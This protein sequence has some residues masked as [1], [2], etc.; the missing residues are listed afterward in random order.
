MKST[1]NWNLDAPAKKIVREIKMKNFM[2]AVRLIDDIA[3]VAEEENHHPD[4]HLTGY[5]NL[6]VELS[7]HALNGLSENDF[8]LAAK[9]NG[10]PM[11]LRT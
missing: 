9:I 7:T 5:R 10:L 3:R 6:R 1:E 11:E 8:I 4:F 2:A